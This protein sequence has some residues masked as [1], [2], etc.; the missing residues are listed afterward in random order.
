MTIE[1]KTSLGTKIRNWR[2]QRGLSQQELLAERFSESYL[3]K[4]EREQMNASEDFLAYV[5]SRLGLTVDELSSEEPIISTSKKLSRDAQELILMEA[6]LALQKNQYQEARDFLNRLVI[7]QLPTSLLAEYYFLG[8]KLELEL[9]NYDKAVLDLEQA[10]KLIESDPKALPLAV[11][12]VRNNL[13]LTHYRRGNLLLALKQHKRSLQVVE[14]GLIAD[15]VFLAKLYYNLANEHQLLDEREQAF[16]F[17]KEAARY[18]ERGE[19]LNEQAGI[20]WGLGLAYQSKGDLTMAKVYLNK[21]AT[22]YE[23]IKSLKYASMVKGMLGKTMVE[24]GEYEA[25]D[26]VLNSALQTALQGQDNETLWT[27]YV[28]LAYLYYE[29]ANLELAERYI[30]LSIERAQSSHNNLLLGQSLA[31]VAEIRLAQGDVKEG[32]RLFAQAE[33][34]LEKNGAAEYLQKICYRYAAALEKL[35]EAQDAM[36]MYR[37]AFEYQKR[38]KN[39]SFR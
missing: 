18:A 33:E 15:P 11:E 20:A 2:T 35:G 21:S 5:A 16:H 30:Q 29:Q 36:K 8:G 37:K 23:S 4:V 19:N 14:D 7:D 12:E 31:Q 34:T 1:V 10:L 32:L 3:S 25:A 6:R 39:D 28:N 24:R 38:N 9:K 17:Y 13:G 26:G 22:L 27:A